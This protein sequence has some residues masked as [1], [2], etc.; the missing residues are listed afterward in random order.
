MKNRTL[1][2]V[3]S[4]LLLLASLSFAQQ[5]EGPPKLVQF[6]M[7]IMKKGP[8]WDSTTQRD[9]N[10]IREQHLGNVISLLNS[11]KAIIVG[12]F[13][14]NSDIAGIFILRASSA[15]DAKAWVESDPAVKAGL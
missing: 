6:Q 15:D 12:P 10:L 9:R 3:I 11:G 13:D 14:D 1:T 5:K 2:T 8:K 4:F 7:A